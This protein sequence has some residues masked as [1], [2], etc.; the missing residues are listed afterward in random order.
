[1]DSTFDSGLPEIKGFRNNIVEVEKL[2]PVIRLVAINTIE[3]LRL[4]CAPGQ[5]IPLH[6][7]VETL[8]NLRL[9]V[10]S[11]SQE[12]GS[13][14][15]RAPTK[16]SKW[17]QKK[18]EG[19]L[20]IPAIPE[21][22]LFELATQQLQ[23][24]TTSP[25]DGSDKRKRQVIVIRDGY[26]YFFFCLLYVQEDN[27]GTQTTDFSVSQP[28]EIKRLRVHDPEPSSSLS[29]F[30][31]QQGDITH[32]S[33]SVPS[34]LLSSTSARLLETSE[35]EPEQE[36]ASSPMDLESEEEKEGGEVMLEENRIVF[37]EPLGISDETGIGLMVSFLES[38]GGN[39]ILT[40]IQSREDLVCTLK[41][42]MDELRQW[43]GSTGRLQ[44]RHEELRG[45]FLEAKKG[46]QKSQ[47][48]QKDA[49]TR[50]ERMSNELMK[51]KAERIQL[52]T[53]L[54]QAR[55]RLLAGPPEIAQLEQLRAENEKLK[56]RL[57]SAENNAQ[58]KERDFDFLRDQ[59][60]Q[61]S[62]GAFELRGDNDRLRKEN[63]ILEKRSD[64]VVV[65]LRALQLENQVLTRDKH[66]ENLSLQLKEREERISRL[67]HERAVNTR[68]RGSVGMRASSVSIRGSPIQSRA[69]SPATGVGF[70]GRESSTHP[71]RNG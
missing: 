64:E 14:I 53:D 33:D 59:Y 28:L 62:N 43:M 2:A 61:A 9:Q 31:Q 20:D 51:V 57:H 46:L 4:C 50:K 30:S 10:G 41:K 67:E 40:A 1:M 48:A 29:A 71:L 21:L 11:A 24:A 37:G 69:T 3:Q 16:I 70:H 34:R 54:V 55:N 49:E 39:Y 63:S 8:K 23:S 26:F 38:S 44:V 36:F 17:L 6:V 42:K 27:M 35:P 68:S 7:Y 56:E 52:Q 5:E 13:A 45:A 60:Q 22:P 18:A 15:S 32:I 25:P 58:T 66:I 19:A 12:Y 65:R 47:K